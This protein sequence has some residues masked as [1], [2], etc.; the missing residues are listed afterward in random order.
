M[1]VSPLS[2]GNPWIVTLKI[3]VYALKVLRSCKPKVCCKY[4]MYD[5]WWDYKKYQLVGWHCILCVF[6]FTSDCKL[7]FTIA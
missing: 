7:G 6:S 3:P 5:V 4:L 2:T 1:T